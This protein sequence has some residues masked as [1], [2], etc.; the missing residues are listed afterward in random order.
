M[1]KSQK[2]QGLVE[3]GLALIL[4]LILVGAFITMW[5]TYMNPAAPIPVISIPNY[6]GGSEVTMT[7][8]GQF[9]TINSTDGITSGAKSVA[10]AGTYWIQDGNDCIFGFTSGQDY[11]GKTFKNSSCPNSP[12]DENTIQQFIR[13]IWDAYKNG[14]MKNGSTWKSILENGGKLAGHVKAIIELAKAYGVDLIP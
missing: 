7:V 3:F 14:T 13:W 8:E 6:I 12:D 5:N 11:I 1:F 2:G 10:G 4:I 9:A